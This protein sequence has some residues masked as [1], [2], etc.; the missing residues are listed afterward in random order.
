MEE[1]VAKAFQQAHIEAAAEKFG[2]NPQSLNEL[3]GFENFIFEGERD[4]K[5]VALRLSHSAKKDLQQVTS[6]LMY[7]H[8]LAEQ[9]AGVNCPLESRQGELICQIPIEH[10]DYFSAVCFTKAEGEH[11]YGNVLNSELVH[12]WGAA[13]GKMHRFSQQYQASQGFERMQWYEEVEVTNPADF[14][15]VG[16]EGVIERM[17]QYTRELQAL[18][19]DRQSYGVIHNDLHPGNFLYDGKKLT[20]IDFEDCVQMWY[21]SDMAISLFMNSVWPPNDLSR[22]DF[23]RQFW[24]LFLRGYRDENEMPDGWVE[25]LPL[26][27]KFR[28][29][30]QYV[31]MY[32]ACDMNNPPPWVARFMDG[33]KERIEQDL[34]FF[35]TY[36]WL[37]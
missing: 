37:N 11:P 13:M 14:L 15:P 21:V 26:F 31:A 12:Q 7:V 33:R 18:P 32:R 1:Y 10:E 4:G 20:M 28:E 27:I 35:D 29:L 30:G 6:E 25:K 24:P 34:P 16:Q 19:N 36:D 22:V 23:A 5:A 8:Y 3:D 2:V 17:Q 9:G